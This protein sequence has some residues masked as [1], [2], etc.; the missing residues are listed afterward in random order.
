MKRSGCFAIAVLVLVSVCVL[1]LT[2][3]VIILQPSVPVKE[4]PPTLPT[5]LIAADMLPA[6]SFLTI[7]GGRI[8]AIA[9]APDGNTL[10]TATSTGIVLY[11]TAE[12]R[13]RL[14]I[15]TGLAAYNVL[16]S[17]DGRQIAAPG[18]DGLILYDAATGEEV[19]RLSESQPA[20]LGEELAW[21]PDGRTIAARALLMYRAHV[22]LWDA[23]TGELIAELR[24][25]HRFPYAEGLAW[26]PD[27]RK[28][29][30][31]YRYGATNASGPDPDELFIWEMGDEPRIAKQWPLPEYAAGPLEW[32]PDGRHL[33][34]AGSSEIH[35]LDAGN[36]HVLATTTVDISLG[37]RVALS[38]SGRQLA[39]G[40]NKERIILYEIPGLT[41]LDEIDV[42][43]SDPENIAWSPDG[44]ALAAASS[45]NSDIFVWSATDRALLA[46]IATGANWVENLA[47]SP[48]SRRLAAIAHDNR[49]HVYAAES[50]DLLFT[51]GESDPQMRRPQLAW[52]PDG[53][54]LATSGRHEEGAGIKEI[55]HLWSD[56]GVP[57]GALPG[58]LGAWSVANGRLVLLND[59][60]MQSWQ[61]GP[62]GQPR[63]G[64]EEPL[65]D[66]G[67]FPSPVD[68][69][70]AQQRRTTDA[71]DT[72]FDW[73][74]IIIRRAEDGAQVIE[75]GEPGM[76]YVRSLAWSPDGR[77]LAAS[78]D[79]HTDPMDYPHARLTIWSTTTWQVVR[80]F[81][82]LSGS[83]WAISWSPDGQW[84]AATDA[85]TGF[86]IT[87]YP[88]RDSDPILEIDGHNGAVESV[89]WSPDGRRIASAGYDGQVII[90]D[91][92]ALLPAAATTPVNP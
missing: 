3:A 6:G 63:P 44:G 29:A 71:T 9:Y 10:A 89:A 55:T 42:S 73:A 40:E 24:N 17:P 20:G 77:W 48:D 82:P 69:F 52:S 32:T 37:N 49:T 74:S 43:N 14:T 88:L 84:V 15:A 87:L 51:V 27:S 64:G 12:F 18:D 80:T 86:N 31:S 72:W 25:R 5:Q 59:G 56:S 13:P 67:Y 65:S 19:R 85:P 46:Q 61:V 62:Q 60:Q 68:G 22:W 36:G 4:S 91:A 26:S 2:V 53:R 66:I 11:D 50:G 34:A 35:V 38:P 16:W 81:S 70:F 75:L 54:V 45:F 28:L 92:A 23:Q 30:V 7:G 1:T 76:S 21:S 33:V 47:W 39:V 78:Y 57:L 79:A 8:H 83:S 58:T 41:K 90:W